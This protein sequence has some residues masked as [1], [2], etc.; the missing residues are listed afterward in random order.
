MFDIQNETILKRSEQ[1]DIIGT[2]PKSVA[3]FTILGTGNMTSNLFTQMKH[4]SI[5]ISRDTVNRSELDLY[6]GALSY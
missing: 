5:D 6:L 4:S 2:S 1:N 3:A